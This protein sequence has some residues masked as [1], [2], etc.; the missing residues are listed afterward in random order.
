MLTRMAQQPKKNL[1]PSKTKVLM[2][3]HFSKVTTGPSLN[4]A[5]DDVITKNKEIQQQNWLHVLHA[6]AHDWLSRESSSASLKKTADPTQLIQSNLVMKEPSVSFF[7]SALHIHTALLFNA[8]VREGTAGKLS[9]EQGEGGRQENEER[10]RTKLSRRK[11]GKLVTTATALTMG[12]RLLSPKN[13]GRKK[14]SQIVPATIF[15]TQD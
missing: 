5:Q 8:E 1:K 10:S 15:A 11:G 3:T 9:E 13:F 6:V 7:S 2:K 12:G 14:K 4:S